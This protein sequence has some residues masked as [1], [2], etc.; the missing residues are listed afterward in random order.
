MPVLKDVTKMGEHNQ[1]NNNVMREYLSDTVTETSE[2]I[3]PKDI[4]PKG[5]PDWAL[6]VARIILEAKK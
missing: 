6:G 5:A 1:K 4:L 3:N 2:D